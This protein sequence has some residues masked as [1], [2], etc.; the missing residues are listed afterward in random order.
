M[1]TYV[2]PYNPWR[3]QLAGGI[4]APLLSDFLTNMRQNEQNR[5]TNSFRGAL[6]DAIS[7]QQQPVTLTP[8]NIPEG[9]N[10]DPWAN[11]FHSSGSPLTQFDLGT[12][13]LTPKTPSIQDIAKAADS[14]AA[15]KRFSMLNP[16]TVDKIRNQQ[17]QRA[18]ADM[19]GNASDP[20]AQ[21]RALAMG[22]AEGVVPHQA[23]A[24]FS[25]WAIK[26]AQPW[27]F[28]DMDIGSHKLRIAN[29][30]K[31]GTASPVVIAPVQMSPYQTAS[32]ETQRD[33]ARIGADS[34]RYQTDATTGTT[35]RGQDL[36]YETENRRIDVTRESNTLN[37]LNT[38]EA[39]LTKQLEE[40][41]MMHFLAETE[42][43][44][45]RTQAI[46]DRINARIK[47]IREARNS[48]ITQTKPPTI[49]EVA[50]SAASPDVPPT[51][52]SPDVPPTATSQDAK[53]APSQG[54]L[55]EFNI[56]DEM[57]YDPVRDKDIDRRLLFTLSDF[58]EKIRD[59]RT[60]P[61][62]KGKYAKY[63][64]QQLILAAYRA[65]W[66]IKQ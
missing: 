26:D 7:S 21:M 61:E 6:Q 31:D 56:P 43:E 17:M 1:A 62:Y 39:N 64:M 24:A 41:E 59:L 50:A 2:T 15:S 48:I 28:S 11:A 46:V 33:I 34:S 19:F 57:A 18:Y 12:S 60:N 29:N 23:L 45:Y 49:A 4:I 52:A 51:A 10:S 20:V 66:R 44:H 65:G 5:K 27:T 40:A 53:P 54:N 8:Q 63:S 9:Y 25:P 16:E 30:A 37:A 32:L 36:N 42:E 14:L 38:E 47:E 13:A 3:E 55:R 58:R 35:R 22:T